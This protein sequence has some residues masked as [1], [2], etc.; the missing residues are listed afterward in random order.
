VIATIPV[1]MTPAIPIFTRDGT[2]AYVNNSGEG[3]ISQI[4]VVHNTV[5]RTIKLPDGLTGSGFALSPDGK[6]AVLTKLGEPGFAVIVDL[7]SG[8]ASSAIPVGNGSERVAITPD[9]KRAYVTNGNPR[10]DGTVTIID[11][12][13]ATAIKTIPVGK[14]PF[15]VVVM[16]DGKTVYVANIFGS[17]ISVIETRSN[18]VINTIPT[19]PFPNG[20]AL[21]R[22][23]RSIYI[24]NFSG[25][26]MQVLDLKTQKVSAPVRT[27]ASPSYLALSADGQQA[28]YVHPL[29]N[30][31]SVVDTKTFGLAGTIIVGKNPT[32]IGACP[33][34]GKARTVAAAKPPESTAAKLAGQ[35][36]SVEATPLGELL[37]NAAARAVVLK[38]LPMIVDNPRIE[39]MRGITLSVARAMSNT[40]ISEEALKAID[41]ELATLPAR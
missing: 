38:H 2:R 30:T 14:F 36:F 17:S 39:M 12:N 23:G 33:F 34:P 37:D 4:D 16:P 21:A 29:G 15:N 7:V 25:G 3:T 5:V 9:G 1:G 20:L 6:R 10:G 11:L 27:S 13:S 19:A 35:R 18:T 24:T 32:A 41:A 31:V 28:Y 26:T 22:N 8:R 40:T